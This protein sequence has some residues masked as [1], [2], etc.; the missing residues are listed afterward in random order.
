MDVRQ[1]SDAL[2]DY[3]AA[4]L[5]VKGEGLAEVTSRAGRRLP[6]R[7]QSAAAKIIEAE[8]LAAH[9]RTERLVDA[10]EIRQAERRL[11]RFLD[12]QDPRKV[13]RDEILDGIA[14][15][16]FVIFVVGLFLFYLLVKRGY[17]G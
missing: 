5:R 6:K 16:A 17:L 14:K 1:R 8:T 4:Q 3:M 13:R 7:L 12:R 15:I 2:A 10:R 11:R 9:P